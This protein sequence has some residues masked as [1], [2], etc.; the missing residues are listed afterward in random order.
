MTLSVEWVLVDSVCDIHPLSFAVEWPMNS[1][2]NWCLFIIY[3]RLW[4]SRTNTCCS[5]RIKIPNM[6]HL[7][8]YV[9]L[10]EIGSPPDAVSVSWSS[11]AHD[12][13]QFKTEITNGDENEGVPLQF[14]WWGFRVVFT[15]LYKHLLKYRSAHWTLHVFSQGFVDVETP[16]LFKR[17]PG[18]SVCLFVFFLLQN[19]RLHSFYQYGIVKE[20]IFICNLCL[21]FIYNFR[22]L[23]TWPWSPKILECLFLLILLNFQ[24]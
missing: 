22:N 20:N 5:S 12:A 15:Y 4:G 16:T 6:F 10:E 9:C 18:V 17:T 2:T 7:N 3:M 24:H 14:T 1:I 13:V 11:V 23:E 19:L 8:S 21:W